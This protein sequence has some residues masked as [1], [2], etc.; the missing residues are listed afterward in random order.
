MRG[1]P[2]VDVHVREHLREV[3]R[4]AVVR[5]VVQEHHR[6]AGGLDRAQQAGQQQRVT[7][8]AGRRR[9]RRTRRGTGWAARG[10]RRTRSGSGA[11]PGR[12]AAAAPPPAAAGAQPARPAA[13]A[14]LRPGRPFGG[15]VQADPVGRDRLEPGRAARPAPR[16]RRGTPRRTRPHRCHSPR[17]HS[18]TCSSR[19]ISRAS[20]P[21][22]VA[23][24][25]GDGQRLGLEAGVHVHR[26]QARGA[27]E[28]PADLFGAEAGPLVQV[29]V[30][31][32]MR[33]QPEHRRAPPPHR[34]PDLRVEQRHPRPDPSR[35]LA[36]PAPLCS[37]SPSCPATHFR[38]TGP[39]ARRPSTP[40]QSSPPAPAS[41][42]R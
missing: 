10:R 2:G 27:Q 31:P 19:T 32:G 9:G 5:V 29:L 11:A 4:L 15:Q 14:D 18:A 39:H 3:A 41:R 37:V 24:S 12:P 17:R 33:G 28:P 25:G 23:I 35:L 20:A 21:A 22:S 6:R 8:A 1:Q 30:R 7:P 36:P 34:Q 42:P 38:P 16:A 13:S 40:A 26:G